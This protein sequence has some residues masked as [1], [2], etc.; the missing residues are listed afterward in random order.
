[1]DNSS[2]GSSAGS[3]IALPRLILNLADTGGNGWTDLLSA[4]QGKGRYVNLNLS[5]CTMDGT[6][7][8]PGTANTGE[9]R[10][11]SLI[12]PA[13]A[14][15][16]KAGTYGNPTFRYF[17][18]LRNIGGA[19]IITIGSEA[20][21]DCIGLASVNLP[22]A[23]GIGGY[24]FSGCTGLTSVSLPVA[25]NIGS[26]AFSGCTG[27]TSVDLP[28]AAGIGD[29]AFR[30]CTGLA[31]VSLPA[32]LTSLSGGAFGGCTSLTDITVDAGNQNFR[33]SDDRKMILNKAGTTLISYPSA[34]GAVTLDSRITGIGDYAFARCT[35]LTSVNLPAATGIGSNAFSGCAG[36]I[37]VS[38]PAAAGIG[39]YAFYGCYGLSS[40]SLPAATSI[41]E[42][43]FGQTS[44]TGSSPLT[45]T[46]GSAVPTLG[47][48]MLS[49]YS[50]TRN[51]TV[52]VPSSAP[53]WSAIIGSSTGNDAG[54]N[55]RNGF[56]GGGWDGSNMTD[57]SKVNGDISLTVTAIP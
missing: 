52:E 16:V 45:V 25:T 47:T 43:A 39:N 33:H 36:L 40:V 21:Y 23:T 3:P 30:D 38:L 46:L 41:G 31:S 17:T 12:L 26:Q 19:G 15:E 10:I 27:L 34:S 29:Y 56:R 51:V 42:K 57:G 53:A 35:G 32:S 1:T 48:G 49:G 6:E 8:D 28:A 9:G 18:S 2:A 54:D 5:A 55:W 11:V 50:G 20:F 44:Y 13:T 14:A 4:L 24:A 7:F 22:A 37:S